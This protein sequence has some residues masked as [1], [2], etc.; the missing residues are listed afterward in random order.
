MQWDFD[1]SLQCHCELVDSPLNVAISFYTSIKPNFFGDYFRIEIN[2]NN[3]RIIDEIKKEMQQASSTSETP[4]TSPA[5]AKNSTLLLPAS[6]GASKTST[7]T[8]LD[9]V[10]TT[11]IFTTMT[12]LQVA[13]ASTINA[14]ALPP[15][16]MVNLPT[17]PPMPR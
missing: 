16:T 15:T 5:A 6:E 9:D 4:S 7:T 14:T 11:P 1:G 2:E 8:T 12:A 10:T 17:A 13:N 3:K